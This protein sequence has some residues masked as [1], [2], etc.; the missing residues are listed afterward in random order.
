MISTKTTNKSIISIALFISLSTSGCHVLTLEQI[1]SFTLMI[2]TEIIRS[3]AV[4]T[5]EKGLDELLQNV[6]HG[7]NK[8]QE[9]YVIIDPN[10]D[11]FLN[12]KWS[13]TM[14]FK[15]TDKMGNVVE[16][17]SLEKPSMVRDSARSHKWRLR[18]DM[19]KKVKTYFIKTKSET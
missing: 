6:F 15:K 9:E 18:D 14:L 7:S 12:G 2:G 13:T 3:A 11:T 5:L 1:F 8:N 10:D 16:A 17:Y 19:Q 4:K